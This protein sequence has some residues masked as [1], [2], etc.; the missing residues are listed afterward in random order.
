MIALHTENPENQILL[1]FESFILE[2]FCGESYQF[3]VLDDAEVFKSYLPVHSLAFSAAFFS[4]AS[5]INFGTLSFRH[6]GL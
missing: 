3:L 2:N 4:S 1:R 6:V 5:D